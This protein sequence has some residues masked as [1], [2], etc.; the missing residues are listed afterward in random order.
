MP[1]VHADHLAEIQALLS[2]IMA[3]AIR[4]RQGVLSTTATLRRIRRTFGGRELD[5]S[6]NPRRAPVEKKPTAS[7]R[8]RVVPKETFFDE[9]QL[10][11]NLL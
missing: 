7:R 11:V 3:L 6:E 8:R 10:P 4:L 2:E 9:H 5:L 1:H